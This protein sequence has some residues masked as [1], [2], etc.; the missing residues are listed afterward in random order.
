EAHELVSLAQQSERSLARQMHYTDVALL[1][2]DEAA[3]ARILRENNQFND[4]LAKLEA[5]GTA[6]PKLVE[7]IRASQDEAM[8]VVADIANAIRD[9]RL[10]AA[11]GAL[12]RRQ[13]RLDN[14]ITSRVG[15]LVAGQ[16]ERMDRLRESVADTN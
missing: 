6:D 1:S 12:L 14:E 9:G 5:A 2:Q 3:I 15:Q 4:R 16:Q 11:T 7:Q 10:G 13:D 8:A